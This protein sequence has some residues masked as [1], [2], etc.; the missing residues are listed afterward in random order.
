MVVLYFTS[1]TESVSHSL[2]M[3]YIS[4]IRLCSFNRLFVNRLLNDVSHL[5]CAPGAVIA[6][7]RERVRAERGRGEK[8]EKVRGERRRVRGERGGGHGRERERVRENGCMRE[9]SE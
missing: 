3:S 5:I 7:S 1:E 6:Y 9:V 8:G 4:H 2:M